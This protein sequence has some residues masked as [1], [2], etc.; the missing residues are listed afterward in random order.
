MSCIDYFHDVFPHGLVCRTVTGEKTAGISSF[1]TV[2]LTLARLNNLRASNPSLST[3]FHVYVN[4]EMVARVCRCVKTC[5]FINVSSTL[6]DYCRCIL[7]IYSAAGQL[8]ELLFLSGFFFFLLTLFSFL[9]NGHIISSYFCL[10]FSNN[11]I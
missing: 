5:I 8:T 2:C 4:V 6:S 1:N 3:Y 11:C 7:N 9:E 10:I